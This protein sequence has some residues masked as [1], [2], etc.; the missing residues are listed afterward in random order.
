MTVALSLRE[1][2]FEKNSV[3]MG[4]HDWKM[5]LVV[6]PDEILGLEKHYGSV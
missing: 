5:D 3:P 6:T 4:E 1:Q 2:L